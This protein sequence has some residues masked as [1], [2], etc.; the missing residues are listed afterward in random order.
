V[1]STLRLAATPRW[2][3]LGLLAL[4]FALAALA[5]GRWQ[6]DRTQDIVLAEQAARAEPVD[7][8]TLVEVGEDFDN[9]LIGRP[10]LARGAYLAGSQTVVLNRS[11][12]DEAGVWVL[13][14]LRFDDG[15]AIAVLR[16]WSPSI[17]DIEP[18]SGIVNVA[19]IWH[20]NER[21]YRDEPMSQDGVMAI[22]SERLRERWELPLLPGYIMLTKQEP[23][24]NL[25]A[26][27]QTVRTA[28]VP[29]PVQ[30]A[31]YAVQWLVFAGFAGFVYF[32]WLRLE[33]RRVP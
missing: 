5:L 27:P 20:P 31:F 8:R 13:T 6:W 11:L 10:V 1:P 26:V 18:P 28:D 21:F 12:D 30:N 19:G 29:F 22:S 15:T 33:S 4:V 2:I 16:G 25:A 14:P 7:I 9:P 17:D 23:E 24:S 32:R 3:A